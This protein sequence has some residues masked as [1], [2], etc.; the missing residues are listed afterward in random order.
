MFKAEMEEQ[1]EESESDNEISNASNSKPKGQIRKSGKQYLSDNNYTHE[2]P[3]SP[4]RIQPKA[5]QRL[6]LMTLDKNSE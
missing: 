3:D 1:S 2:E 6:K 4:S 5:K